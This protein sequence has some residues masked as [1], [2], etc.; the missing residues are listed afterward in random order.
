MPLSRLFVSQE[1]NI[2]MPLQGMRLAGG[3]APSDWFAYVVNYH[4]LLL[5]LSEFTAQYIFVF[6]GGASATLR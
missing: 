6:C 4:T 1:S 3:C 5:P 2:A